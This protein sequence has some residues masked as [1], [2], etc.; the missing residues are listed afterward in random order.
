MAAIV[1]M[2]INL[3]PR[4]IAQP[5]IRI[6]REGARC[7]VR[8][9]RRRNADIHGPDIPAIKLARQE[10][11]SCLAPEERDRRLRLEGEAVNRALRGVD[12]RWNIDRDY[13][14]IAR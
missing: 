2:R 13:G 1:F 12:A 9:N 14:E 10:H 11:M 6:V 4:E 3:E 8:Q 7:D 5:E